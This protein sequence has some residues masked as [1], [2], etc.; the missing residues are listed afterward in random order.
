MTTNNRRDAHSL[1]SVM[2]TIITDASY[3]PGTGHAA[4]AGRVIC[5]G[6]A[7]DFYGPMKLPVKSSNDAELAALVNTLH[8]VLRRGFVPRRA[9]LLFQTDSMHVVQLVNYHFANPNHRKKPKTPP[10]TNDFQDTIIAYLVKT[11]RTHEPGY[12]PRQAPR[13]ASQSQGPRQ[14]APHSGGN[15]PSGQEGAPR[16]HGYQAD[17][18]RVV[19][20]YC[21]GSGPWSSHGAARRFRTP[22]NEETIYFRL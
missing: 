13:G 18:G 21:R 8:I 20:P 17:L 2:A 5:L 1:V 3:H 14:P 19:D 4:W 15:G 22:Q 6:Q 12:R 9:G 10:P 16:D 11:F 7:E